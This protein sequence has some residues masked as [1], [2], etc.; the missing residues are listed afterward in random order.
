MRGT[1]FFSQNVGNK[2]KET[3]K[4]SGFNNIPLPGGVATAEVAMLDVE[5]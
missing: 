1:I 3:R 4:A 5:S 2:E